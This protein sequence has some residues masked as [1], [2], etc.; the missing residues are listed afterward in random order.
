M[1]GFFEGQ[2]VAIIGVSNSPTNLGALMVQNLIEFG[3]QGYIHLVG[4]KGG[5]LFGH[6][7]YPTVMDI[8]DPVDVASV[9]V[10]AR[11]VPEILRQ[12]G[13]KGIR[14]VV[15]QSGGFREM[16]EDR[17]SLEEEVVQTL[18]RYDMRMIG[19][20]GIGIMNRNNGLA[21]P[22]MLFRAVGEPGKTSVAAQSG[23]IGAMMINSLTWENLGFSKFASIG[24]KL[25]VDEADLL[26]YFL[27][28]EATGQVYLYLE[29]ISNGR[30]LMEIASRSS[31]P[32]VVQK[33]NKSRPGAAMARSHSASLSADDKV[34]DAAFLQCGIIRV[35][36]QR[37]ALHCLKAFSL[38]QMRG[39]R[40]AVISRSGGHAVLAADAAEELGF[41]LPPYPQEAIQMVREYSRAG[42]IQLQ[43]PMDLGDL[44]HL[45]LYRTLIEQTL[46]REDVDGITFILNYN[47]NRAL[48]ESR[49]LLGGLGEIM[50]KCGKPIAVCIFTVQEEFEYLRKTL[51]YP[52]F[53]DPRDAVMALAMSRDRS[54][55]RPLPFSSDRPTGVD[56]AEARKRLERLPAGPIAPESLASILDAY[57]IGL[58]SWKRAE[59]EDAAA[60]EAEVLG[61]PVALKTAHAEVLHK[62]DVGGVHLNLSDTGSV[63]EAYRK[64]LKLGPAVLVQKMADPGL[65][66]LVG[67]RQDPSFGPA[68]VAGLGGIYVEIFRETSI[69]IA[70]ITMEEAGRMVDRSRGAALVRGARGEA[71]LDRQALCDALVRISWL[72]HDFPEIQELDLNPVRLYPAGCMALDWRATKG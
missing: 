53:D 44:F 57:G 39:P 5:A 34:V 32:I 54:E 28:D 10:P 49:R 22:F 36:D 16:G 17:L 26:E 19:P 2:S 1:R 31:K 72:L 42:V 46:T 24:N 15:V 7:I 47:G 66:W 8:P 67:G 11:A 12:C 59:S 55:L 23:G 51:D 35:P 68:V 14:R 41:A 38:P 43:N 3:Y 69:R 56:T 4:P 45:P 9:L 65:E 71:P 50:Q 21:V 37:T 64:L 20:N 33:A 29:G 25:D 30:R 18:R 6:K 48:V 60:A 52:I 58:V 63:R 62:S 13:E 40:L 70:P 61:Y 27:V